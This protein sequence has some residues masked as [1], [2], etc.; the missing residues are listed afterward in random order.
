MSLYKQLKKVQH[1]KTWKKIQTLQKLYP[2]INPKSDWLVCEFCREKT[3]F[4]NVDLFDNLTY[5]SECI[6][7]IKALDFEGIN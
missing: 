5:C 2:V 1:N 7:I 6:P 3:H 4:I